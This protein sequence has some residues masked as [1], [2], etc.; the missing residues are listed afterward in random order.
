MLKADGRIVPVE[1]KHVQ[2]R[3]VAHRLPGL[4]HQQ[5]TGDLLPNLEVGDVIEVKW[6]VRGKNPEHD[7]QFFNRYTFGD[8][9]YPVVRDELR[10]RL[11]KAK[12][13]KHA[14]V[15][16]KLEPEIKEEGGYRT[17]H[18]RCAIGRQLPPDDNLPSKEELRLQVAYSTFASWDEVC[19]WKR[20]LRQDCWKCTEELRKVVGEVTEGLKTPEDKARR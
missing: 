1:A 3:D 13:L 15:G 4:R 17:Y 16:G 5:A 20:K 2:L 9:R 14:T 7:G 11:P 6:T 18:W 8:D 12:T 10:L 19:Q